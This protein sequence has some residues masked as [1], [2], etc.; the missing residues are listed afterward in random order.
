MLRPEM[1]LQY[2]SHVLPGYG[3]LRGLSPEA[4]KRQTIIR[5]ALA[6]EEAYESDLL[7]LQRLFIDDLRRADPPV[8]TTRHLLETFIS[9]C[10]G[11]IGEVLET[12]RR[13]IDSFKIRERES[14][15][16][17]LILSVGDIFLQAAADFRGIYPDYTG[18]LPQA[19]N[20][21]KRELEENVPFRLYCEVSESVVTTDWVACR[22]GE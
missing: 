2:P 12:C 11:N 4:F 22:Q 3:I 9:E 17:P 19:E 20:V 14:E 6:S 15:Q 8:F 1:S 7:A 5:Q 18:N 21:L 16:M 13:L 10:F